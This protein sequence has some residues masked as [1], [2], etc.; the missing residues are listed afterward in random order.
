MFFYLLEFASKTSSLKK[1]PNKK[2]AKQIFVVNAAGMG[3]EVRDL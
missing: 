3:R 2:G 1:E